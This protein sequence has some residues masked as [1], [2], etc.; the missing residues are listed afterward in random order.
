MYV[1][2]IW[3]LKIQFRSISNLQQFSIDQY[4]YFHRHQSRF[5]FRNLDFAIIID[6]EAK[7][8]LNLYVFLK[9]NKWFFYSASLL[10][11]HP[12]S[13]LFFRMW[14]QIDTWCFVSYIYVYI[15]FTKNQNQN[16]ERKKPKKRERERKERKHPFLLS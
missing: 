1:Y 7:I 11:L 6:N 10:I 8:S 2:L 5:L 9:F 16:R 12:I 14:T 4:Q 13:L 15:Y 3:N